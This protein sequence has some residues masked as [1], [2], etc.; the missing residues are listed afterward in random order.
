MP[1]FLTHIFEQVMLMTIYMTM[2]LVLGNRLYC[3]TLLMRRFSAAKLPCCL[4]RFLVHQM[5]KAI[6]YCKVRFNKILFDS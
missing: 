6:T 3:T 2:F 1:K 5:H 4:H